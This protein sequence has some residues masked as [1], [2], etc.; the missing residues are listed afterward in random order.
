[1]VGAGLA[2]CE[3]AWQLAERGLKVALFEMKPTS[4]SPA[5]TTNG[6]A[7]LVCSN[8][9]RGASLASAVGLL[10]QELAQLGSLAMR[11]AIQTQIPAGRALAVD[12]QRFSDAVEHA[13]EAHP[14]IQIVR[15]RV[16]ELPPG[17]VIVATGPLTAGRLMD[18]LEEKGALLYYHDAIAPLVTA[19]SLDMNRVFAAS[20]YD[21][22]D[23]K[24][25]ERGAYLNCPMDERTYFHF[26]EQLVVGERAP[27]KDFETAPFFEGCLPVEEIAVRG[28][29]TLAH[30]PLKP[31]GLM[32]PRTGKRPFAV[33]QLRREDLT[34]TAYNLVGFQTRLT[35]PEQKRIFQ[36]IPGMEE[37]KFIRFG[38]VH[39]NSFV[40]APVVLDRLL[41]LRENPQ[42]TLAG[43]ISGV[44]G[45]VESIACGWAAGFFTAQELLGKPFET[46]PPTTA[47][48]GLLR[49][50]TIARQNF[51]P[52]N[53][54]W[55]M[56][57]T[58]K[59]ARRVSK[60]RHREISAKKALEELRT[61][62]SANE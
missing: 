41:R 7:E 55:L 43:Q 50:L 61:W 22:A 38:Q 4:R 8:S 16:D 21:D 40:N 28:P 3:A 39:R 30:G 33:V 59:R 48:G 17:R 49:F 54:L 42:I 5:H 10:K 9:F 25:S 52:S 19:E 36:M 24:E 14:N 1:M 56:I 51:Q 26:V 20:R 18:A 31:V 12:R 35:R 2:G 47:I 23:T 29:L 11:A 15:E 60:S 13:I 27:L 58:P 45:Y 34:G 37:A 44:E 32:D 6:M 46:P 62:H 53:V 57:D